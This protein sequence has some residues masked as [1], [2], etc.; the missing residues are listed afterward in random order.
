MPRGPEESDAVTLE[1]SNSSKMWPHYSPPT[2]APGED[3]SALVAAIEPET[4]AQQ[5]LAPEIPADAG[6]KTLD[7]YEDFARP[8]GE[9]ALAGTAP[10][11]RSNRPSSGPA[12][13]A[14]SPPSTV[15][16]SDPLST[17][18]SQ[19]H[20]EPTP[21]DPSFTDVATPAT[22]EPG[23]H[24][25][26]LS[27]SEEPS[28]PIG[29]R[30]SVARQA[31]K[32]LPAALQ[33]AVS[34]NVAQVDPGESASQP[35][36]SRQP[37]EP[38]EALL[39]GAGASTEAGKEPPTGKKPGIIRRY[40][41]AIAIVLL[42]V[43]AGGAVA[44]IA[45]F[46]GPV[47]QPG[48]PTRA[49]DQAAADNVVLRASDFPTAWRV[50][51]S[52]ITASSYGIGSALVTPAIVHS[53]ITAHP[54]CAGDLN[55][56]SA[57][58][59]ASGGTVTAVASTHATAADPLGGSWQAADVV[60]F[61]S[62]AAQ[63]S[64][65]LAAMRSLLAEPA[66]RACIN[67]FWSAALLAGLPRGSYLSLSVSQPPSPVLPG[68]PSVWVMAMGGT[69]TVRSIALP[70]RFEVTS[71]AVG[72]AQVSFVTSSKLAPLPLSLDQAL[73]VVLATRAELPAS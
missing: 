43:A 60:A 58:L 12:T 6:Q 25:P 34:S 54:A 45:A 38:T 1:A 41:S 52:G 19:A 55:S 17:Q 18:S 42:F 5:T 31:R 63:V 47:T 13:A 26:G 8:A 15:E 44:G 72:R 35:V 46:R 69:A 4:D 20:L 73:L 68:N 39:G 33:A 51:K 50:S 9:H 56:L 21:P 65:D 53:W 7:P 16:S 24:F 48:L 22:S 32:P 57:A 70:F 28:W 2:P 49:Q 27:D 67:R 30:R 40:A 14:G 66:A 71:F 23:L 10:R 11:R 3:P 59:T 64:T 29:E 37:P 36:A 62:S 61:H